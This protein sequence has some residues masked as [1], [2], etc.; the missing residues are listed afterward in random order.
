MKEP[1]SYALMI[2]LGLQ[3]KT[4]PVRFSYARNQTVLA[5]HAPHM[6]EGT[7]PAATVAARRAAN[8]RARKSRRVNRERAR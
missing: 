2:L 6:Y 5:D 4:S 3:H 8:R 7:V 1:S